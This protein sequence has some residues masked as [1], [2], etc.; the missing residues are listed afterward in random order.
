LIHTFARRE[1]KARRKI[2]KRSP[3]TNRPPRTTT[4]GTMRKGVRRHFWWHDRTTYLATRI[5]CRCRPNN[6]N[7]SHASTSDAPSTFWLKNHLIRAKCPKQPLPSQHLTKKP[8]WKDKITPLFSFFFFLLKWRK[9]HFII[10]K[11]N[12]KR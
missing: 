5:Y 1:R 6:T 11:K 12:A 2:K 7:V 9:Y 4:H 10:F 3:T 8:T